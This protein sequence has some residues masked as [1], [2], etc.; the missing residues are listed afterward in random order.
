MVA[1]DFLIWSLLCHS[2]PELCFPQTAFVEVGNEQENII[3]IVNWYKG[4]DGNR[5]CYLIDNWALVTILDLWYYRRTRD[6]R[7]NCYAEDA[8]NQLLIE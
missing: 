5:P 4:W 6:K 7:R 1:D 8:K 2:V 3:I